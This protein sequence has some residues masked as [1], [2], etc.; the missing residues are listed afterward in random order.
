MF[1]GKNIIYSHLNRTQISLFG[2]CAEC[3]YKFELSS[4]LY[5]D[6][7]N[8]WILSTRWKPHSG[9]SELEALYT[10]WQITAMYNV[11]FLAISFGESQQNF[12]RLKVIPVHTW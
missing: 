1:A 5:R 2:A 7:Q 6:S 8:K 9:K 4:A 3:A 10:T 11:H 12:Q